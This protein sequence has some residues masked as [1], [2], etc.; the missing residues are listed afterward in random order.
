MIAD[1]FARVTQADP[2]QGTWYISRQDVSVWVDVSSLATGC[3][4]ESNGTMAEDASWLWQVCEDKHINV[5]ELDSVLR[6]INL[7]LQWK[8]KTIHLWMNSACMHR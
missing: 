2:V 8:A 7:G 3:V 4:V 5:A 1:I 6:G